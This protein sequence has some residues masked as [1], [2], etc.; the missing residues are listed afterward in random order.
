MGVKNSQK[1]IAA[2]FDM[3]LTITS[4]DSFRHFIMYEYLH[5]HRNWHLVPLV[6]FYGMMRKFRVISLQTFKEKALVSLIGKS[7]NYIRKA[8]KVFFEN[9]LVN[10]IR[11]K[12]LAKIAWHKERDSLV[13]VITSCPDI[14]ILPLAEY[15]QCDGYEC[16][17]LAYRDKKFIGRFDGNECFGIE[18]V[19]KLKKIVRD[20]KLVLADSYAYSDHGS[21]LPM[22]EMVGYPR[23]VSPTVELRRVAIERSWKI[24]VW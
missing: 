8:G 5:N 11:E 1:K 3:D 24:E 13:F 12:A 17:R 18:K 2:F 16:S 15:L 20:R 22:L 7:E 19:E 21:D 10:I 23:A 4:S 6:F 14:Y 9:Y